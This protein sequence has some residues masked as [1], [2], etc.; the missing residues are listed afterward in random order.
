MIGLKQL[1][2][3]SALICAAAAG[4]AY[5]GESVFQ[6]VRDGQAE[7]VLILPENPP[8]P[9]LKAAAEFSAQVK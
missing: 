7:T 6:L 2:C 8:E 3:G 1:L 9:V 4:T 5:A